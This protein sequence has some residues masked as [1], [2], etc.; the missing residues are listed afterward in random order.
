MIKRFNCVPM[1]EE[2]YCDRC[3]QPMQLTRAEQ[4]FC[5]YMCSHCDNSANVPGPA[6]PRFGYMKTEEIN[7]LLTAPTLNS[8]P[9]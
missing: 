4:Q 5:M 1:I 7:D 9:V 3:G 6:F 8:E 2:L